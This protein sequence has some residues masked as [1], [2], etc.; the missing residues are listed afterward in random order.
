[1][2]DRL[3]LDLL[4]E[5]TG[6][7]NTKIKLSKEDK[8]NGT[9]VYCKEP[10]A[11]E[12]YDIMFGG[13][14]STASASKDLIENEVYTVIAKTLSYEHKEIYSEE[15]NSK[16]TIVIP[17]KECSKELSELMDSEDSRKF[18]VKIYKASKTGEY[19]ASE[20]RAQSVAF[21]QELFDH[22]SN[23]T[24]FSVKLI[25]LIKGGYLALYK[26][27]IECFV[28]GSLAAAN[29]IRDFSSLLNTNINV[30]VDNYDST[31]NLFILS[32]KKYVVNSMATRVT[33]L[34]FGAE[35]TGVLTTKPYDFGIFVEF[36]GYFTGLVHKSE[37]K[38]YDQ[39]CRELKEGDTLK[40]YVKDV[41]YKKGQHRVVLTLDPTQINDE[42]IQWQT[43]R[44]RTENQCF[45]YIINERKN[46]ISI[47]LD[48]GSF[49]VSLKRQ[50][51]AKNL[52]RYPL[53]KVFKVDPINKRLNFE[54]VE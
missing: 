17:F 53:V 19:Y 46:S 25:K 22:H 29:I 4:F 39:A 28:P 37:F 36:E 14:A 20:K 2:T 9:K 44:D 47:E 26:N 32:Y 43:L 8:S 11:Q 54:F 48:G 34:N 12:L 41:I 16:N 23:N 13:T 18:L 5:N 24:W 15:I 40:V 49:E 31:N 35:Y 52:T 30:M 38:N 10:Y 42:K 7:Y 45:K 51:L 33:E 1:M 27:Q 50:D 6:K 3:N 21:T